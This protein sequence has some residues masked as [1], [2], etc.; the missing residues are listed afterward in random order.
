[1][2]VR[3]SRSTREP[4]AL[5]SSFFC[6]LSIPFCLVPLIFF[7]RSYSILFIHDLTLSCSFIVV[8]YLVLHLVIRGLGRRGAAPLDVVVARKEVARG[9]DVVA[10]GLGRLR[11]RT[12]GG[13]GTQGRTRGGTVGNVAL[14]VIKQLVP[15]A[16]AQTATVGG[17]KVHT[18]DN[19][20]DVATE[21][22]QHHQQRQQVPHTVIVENDHRKRRENARKHDQEERLDAVLL[23]HGGGILV[24]YL[25]IECGSCMEPLRSRRARASERV[26][27][28][29]CWVGIARW[30]CLEVC[31][32]FAWLSV[33]SRVLF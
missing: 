27:Q 24:V 14:A 4:T 10:S 11:L 2:V 6:S 9:G 7:V 19:P 16:T 31:S 33:V 29:G 32:Q 26:G 3:I 15:V 25:E 5:L 1:M 23:S 8:T 18:V 28:C 20:G 30:L 17:N 13:G 21:G 12:A 22:Q